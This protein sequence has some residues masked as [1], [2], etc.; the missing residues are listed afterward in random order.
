MCE[1]KCEHPEKLQGKPGEC[2]KEQKKECH[3]DENY[4]GEK[5]EE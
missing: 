4:S 2:S 1:C 3:G 5:K